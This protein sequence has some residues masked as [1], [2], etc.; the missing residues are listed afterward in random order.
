MPGQS[1]FPG[2]AG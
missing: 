2:Q 1:G